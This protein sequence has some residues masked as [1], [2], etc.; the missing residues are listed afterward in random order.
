MMIPKPAS[1]VSRVTSALGNLRGVVATPKILKQPS[2]ST[3]GG[4]AVVEE[5]AQP[6]S[7]IGGGV[8]VVNG[9]TTPPNTAAAVLNQTASS[10]SVAANTSTGLGIGAGKSSTILSINKKS[11]SYYASLIALGVLLIAAVA[12]DMGKL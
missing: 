6:T 12:W 1:S 8:V 3:G 7:V 10:P 9:F 2:S 4:Q 5:F 11:Q